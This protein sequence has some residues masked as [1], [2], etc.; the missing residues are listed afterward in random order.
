M[1]VATTGSPKTL[2]HSPTER[3]EVIIMLPRS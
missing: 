2:P 1:A 3:L